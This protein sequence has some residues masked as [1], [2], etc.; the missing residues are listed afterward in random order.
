VILV[1]PD[2]RDSAGFLRHIQGKMERKTLELADGTMFD[3]L[4]FPTLSPSGL[5]PHYYSIH[6]PPFMDGRLID[7]SLYTAG[8]CRTSH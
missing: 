7:S 5:E 2:E 6:L 3:F 1:L 8:Y 4:H